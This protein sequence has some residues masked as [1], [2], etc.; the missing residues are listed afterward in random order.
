[1]VG[2][3][4]IELPNGSVA[5]APC[6]IGKDCDIGTD[7]S[8]GCLAHVGRDVV[9]GDGVRIQGGAY[10]ADGTQVANGV[11]IGPN[12]TILNDRYPPSRD[13]EKWESVTIAAGAVIGGSATILPG[14]HVGSNAV[15]AAGA[16]LTKDIPANEVWT[17]NPASFHSSRE[18]Y[19]SRRNQE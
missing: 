12:A 3:E 10:V 15:V 1:M 6:Y 17:G 11:F 16:L 14:I 5:W 19:E 9:L 13:P 18:V 2:G 7:V 8:I 4:R